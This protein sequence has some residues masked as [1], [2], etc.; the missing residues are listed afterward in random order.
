M[1]SL[2]IMKRKLMVKCLVSY[3]LIII[4]PTILML[5]FTLNHVNEIIKNEMKNVHNLSATDVSYVI[6]KRFSSIEKLSESFHYNNELREL[7]ENEQLSEKEIVYSYFRNIVPFLNEIQIRNNYLDSLTVYSD[8]TGISK[9]LYD[10]KNS[11]SVI[12]PEHNSWLVQPANSSI[13]IIYFCNLYDSAYV[14]RI[15]TVGLTCSDKVIFSALGD[16]EMGTWYL[17][18]NDDI[19]FSSEDADNETNG[20]YR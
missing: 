5:N 13:D 6:N 14:R 9:L 16:Y 4:S 8:N 12:L 17:L 10:F 20:Q 15:G 18:K 3:L 11:D 19:I 1:M 2:F 7:I